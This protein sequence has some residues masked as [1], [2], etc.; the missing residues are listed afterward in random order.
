MCLVPVGQLVV[1]KT[2]ENGF[3]EFSD[4]FVVALRQWHPTATI[5]KSVEG[6][7]TSFVDTW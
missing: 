7:W 4:T 3:E 5:N 1:R 2:T 6:S